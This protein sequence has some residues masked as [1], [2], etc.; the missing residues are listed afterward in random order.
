MRVDIRSRGGAATN[1]APHTRQKGN[2]PEGNAVPVAELLKFRHHAVRDARNAW[3]DAR[4]GHH[5]DGHGGR[6]VRA[7]DRHHSH[8][9]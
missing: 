1:S 5:E 7:A 2:A 4:G 6:K 8:F 3:G 9:A